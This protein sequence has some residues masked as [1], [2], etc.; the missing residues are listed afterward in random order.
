MAMDRAKEASIRRFERD[1][2][3]FDIIQ[4]QLL[5]LDKDDAAQGN[6]R[7]RS[8]KGY[9][10]DGHEF[11]IGNVKLGIKIQ[12]LGIAKGRQHPSQIGRNILHN[13]RK[14]M[15]FCFSVVVKTK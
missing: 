11:Q 3:Q 8:D 9:K 14:A 7:H 6:D 10:H 12:I 1:Q 5:R 4:L 13:E 2:Y 15:Y